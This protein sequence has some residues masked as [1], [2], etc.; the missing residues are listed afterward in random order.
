MTS[1][2][3]QDPQLNDMLDPEFRTQ[4]LRCY[5]SCL[6]LEGPCGD[7]DNKRIRLNSPLLRSWQS[8]Y[9]AG[10][11][12]TQL[13]TVLRTWQSLYAAINFISRSWKTV[14]RT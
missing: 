6:C 5:I 3:D 10:N 14:L 8:L 11:R 13:A 1:K 12:S 2:L 7:C 4:I 9:A